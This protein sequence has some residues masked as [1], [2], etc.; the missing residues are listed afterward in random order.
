MLSFRGIS[1]L[2]KLPRMLQ[3]VN[4]DALRGILT[5][6]HQIWLRFSQTT[7]RGTNMSAEDE[8]GN[9]RCCCGCRS[10]RLVAWCGPYFICLYVP[11]PSFLPSLLSFLLSF[12]SLFI[13]FAVLLLFPAAIWH[14]SF[15]LCPIHVRSQHLPNSQTY[16]PARK[17]RRNGART[18][19]GEE[20]SYNGSFSFA[21]TGYHLSP[22]HCC[23]FECK[24]RDGR[25]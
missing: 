24:V 8:M 9:P 2:C 3:R 19:H 15:T 7:L 21:L 13:A 12:L 17:S 14:R 18:R 20:D 25:H 1:L 23:R 11:L 16:Q 10:D 5:F 22:R 4:I 6:V